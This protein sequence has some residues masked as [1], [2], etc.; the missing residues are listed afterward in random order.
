MLENYLQLLDTLKEKKFSEALSR[1]RQTIVRL[2]N[3]DKFSVDIHPYLRGMNTEGEPFTNYSHDPDRISQIKEIINAFYHAELALKDAEAITLHTGIKQLIDVPKLTLLF[4]KNTIHHIYRASYLVTHLDIDLMD[5]FSREL[6]FLAPLFDTFHAYADKYSEETRGLLLQINGHDLPRKLGIM[7]GVVVDQLDMQGG[8]VDYEFLTH[9]SAVLPG[10]LDQLSRYIERFSSKVSEREPGIDKRK[11]DELQRDALRLLKALDGARGSSML[12]PLKTLNYIHIIRHTITLSMSIFEQLGLLNETSQDTVRDK[13]AQLKYELFPELLGLTDK[14]EEQSILKPGV[15]SKPLMARISHYYQLLIEYA[16]IF[17]DFSQ[18]GQEL[19]TIEDSQFVANR[20]EYTYRRWAEYKKKLLMVDAAMTASIDFFS[21]LNKS[22]YQGMRLIDLSEKLREQLA[23]HYKIMQP[24]VLQFNAPLNNAI[25]GGLTRSKEALEARGLFGSFSRDLYG[26]NNVL[27][28][29]HALFDRLDKA[30]ATHEFHAKLNTDIIA[31]ISRGVEDLKLFPH[32]I[33]ENPF[34]INEAIILRLGAVSEL[35]Q[36]NQPR[37]FTALQAFLI[38]KIEEKILR[39]V[40]ASE[41]DRFTSLD[42]LTGAE[43]L[44]LYQLYQIKHLKLEKAQQA[45]NQFH[46]ILNTEAHPPFVNGNHDN[47]RKKLRDLYRIFQPY[48]V[49]GLSFVVGTDTVDEGTEMIIAL[50]EAIVS[51]LSTSVVV[52]GPQQRVDIAL[53]PILAFDVRLRGHFSSANE[54][55]LERGSLFAALV[56]LRMRQE[57]EAKLLVLDPDH[58]DRAYHVVKHKKYSKIISDFWQS[59]YKLTLMYNDSVRAQLNGV[60]TGIP[61]PELEDINQVLAQSSQVLGLKRLF[62]C[63]FHLEGISVCMEALN[64]G[65]SEVVYVYHILQVGSHLREALELMQVLAATPYLSVVAGEI[66]Q[67]CRIG[68]ATLMELRDHYSPGTIDS[69]AD[70][71]TGEHTNFF[72]LLNTILIMPEHIKLLRDSR[73]LSP[74]KAHTIHQYTEKVSTDIERILRNSS[75]Y[76]K[77]FLEIPTMYDLFGTLKIKLAEMAAATHSVVFDNLSKINDEVITK[78]LIEADLWEDNL[79]LIPGTLTKTMKDIL[80]VFYQ[81]LLEPLG[82]HSQRHIALVTSLFPIEQRILAATTRADQAELEQSNLLEKQKVITRLLAR[83]QRYSECNGDAPGMLSSLRAIM[84]LDYKRTLP[85]L[86]DVKKH[87]NPDVLVGDVTE[88]FLD[89]SDQQRVTKVG[90]LATAC[91]SYFKGLHASQKLIMDTARGKIKFLMELKTT[92]QRLNGNYSER[93]TQS[94]FEKQTISIATHQVGLVHCSTEYNHQLAA[95][96]RVAKAEIVLASKGAVDIHQ[97]LGQ[98]LHARA[99][100]FE[101]ANIKDY[102][103]LEQVIAAISRLKR[104]N[105]KSDQEIKGHVSLFESEATLR[106]KQLLA[107]KLDAFAEDKAVLVVDRLSNIKRCVEEA[108][109]K[110]DILKY[111]FYEPFT[112]VWLKQWIAS[113]LELIRV[114]TPE[115]Q[116]CYNDLKNAV[117]TPSSTLGQVSGPGLFTVKMKRAYPL[118]TIEVD[119]KQPVLA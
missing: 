31:S 38:E 105:N 91:F 26:I 116:Y 37:P 18:K 39:F 2:L 84:I 95:Y 98:Q 9:F 30:H 99:K 40:V 109:F 68:Y 59:L 4:C 36:F 83:I 103:H 75:S 43:A 11:L 53:A 61:F 46:L 90:V 108:G 88:E 94:I 32:N 102:Y 69:L 65:S 112:F 7:S 79:A 28:E 15:L 111:Q 63:L 10:Y 20:L 101:L 93:Y 17:V 22:E 29:K 42:S 52:F 86:N 114:Y 3:G 33:S 77:L 23:A 73:R 50:D 8:E 117:K 104:Y 80:D 72:Y 56:K 16:V 58:V 55:L 49:S 96:M 64:D 41:H 81:G 118:P 85:L 5:M 51:A 24:Y 14:L 115:R 89:G 48:L 45:Y 35:N 82:L 106:T 76:F 74:E 6:G 113:F 25:I 71:Q 21:I 27:S 13:L 87:L 54:Q 62:N 119:Y 67:K 66:L 78:M 19:V 92:Q 110:A 34:S 100:Q 47:L 107:T 44:T 12:M 60:K 70:D 97:Q 57:N 1:A